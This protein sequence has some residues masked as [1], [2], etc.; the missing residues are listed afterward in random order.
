MG[1]PLFGVDI[2]GIVAS[3]MGSGLPVITLRK[4]TPGTRTD[5]S[6]TAGTNPKT[7]TATARGFVDTYKDS[8]VNG[9]TIKR[10][11]RYATILGDTISPA[12]IPEP[13]DEIV[14]ANSLGVSETF[15]IVEDGVTR[16]PAAATYTCH[17]R[18]R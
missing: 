4:K 17:V 7:T 9:T 6:L 10:G 14:A 5:G 1:I 15:K 11:D 8:Q 18:I 2:S 13:G 16:D 12:I 3:S